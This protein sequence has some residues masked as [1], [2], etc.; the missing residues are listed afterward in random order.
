MKERPILFSGPMVRAILEGRKTQTR[1]IADDGYFNDEVDRFNHGL[2]SRIVCP[3]GQQGDRLIPAMV[4]TGYDAKYAADIKGRLWSQSTGI[5]KPI[6]S[7]ISNSGYERTTLRKGGADVN[8]SVHVVVCEAWYGPA[9]KS[10]VKPCVRHLSGDR[11]DNAPENLDWGNYESNWLDRKAHGRGIHEDHHNAK[12]TMQKAEE[13]RVSGKSAWTLSKE[14]NLSPKT[15]ARILKN[16]TW[17]P[18]DNRIDCSPRWASRITLEITDVRMERLQDISEKDALA[19]GL[20]SWPWQDGL[21]YGFAGG[22]PHGYATAT[23]AFRALWD[24]INKDRASWESNPWVWVVEFI[25]VGGL[26][27]DPN[28]QE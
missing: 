1:R 25:P 15:I 5:W 9:P 12:C 6:K 19:E 11:L 16:E 2:G 23:G 14:Y 13:M 18:F 8:V 7:H 28:R 4:L 21:A 24:S 10:I 20:V 22:A 3:Y 26:Y 17:I 27:E